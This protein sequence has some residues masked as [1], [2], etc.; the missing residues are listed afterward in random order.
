HEDQRTERTRLLDEKQQPAQHLV[1]IAGDD[2]LT[3]QVVQVAVGVTHGR[4]AFVDPASRAF[5]EQPANVLE[6]TAQRT[7]ANTPARL[8]RAVG[9][10]DGTG[11]LEIGPARLST[12]FLGTLRVSLPEVSQHVARDETMTEWLEAAPAG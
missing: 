4:V 7:G 5:V 9:Q 8:A 3:Q 11:D 1:G 10:E 12:C 6:V 2:L